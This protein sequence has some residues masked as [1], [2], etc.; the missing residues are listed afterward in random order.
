MSLSVAVL[1]FPGISPFHLSVP[2]I[3]FD[4]RALHNVGADYR[5][6]I[7]A[8]TPGSFPT[9]AGYDIFV[10][11]DLDAFDTADTIVIPS[12]H[13]GLPAS[14]A[15]LNSLRAA[16]ARG[17]RVVGLCLGAFLVADCGIADGREITTHWEFVQQ[18]QEQSPLAEVRGDPL[19]VDLGDLVTSAGVA[20]ALDCCLHIVRKDYGAA[21]ANAVARQVVLAPHRLGS[22]AQYI[23]PSV[24]DS[25]KTGPIQTV[26]ERA[27]A[28]L[29]DPIDLDDWARQALMSRRTFT[30]RFREHTGTS[31][32]QWLLTQRLFH[33][34]SLLESSD[35]TVEQI[36]TDV[37]FATATSLRQHFQ[38]HFQTSP[39]A[40]RREFSSVL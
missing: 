23:P 30:R 5:V 29:D 27:L 17:A 40:H 7:C 39:Q 14:D 38:Q 21:A 19:W 6:T 24:L 35:R 18:L 15:L 26:M 33:A 22:Q 16:H 13:P 4:N 28:R 12:W 9:S 32:A 2:S 11:A 25:D 37:G 34:K 3:V 36:A 8:E 20:A 1:A 10:H 31:P